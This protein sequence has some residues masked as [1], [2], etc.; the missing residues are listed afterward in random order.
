[1]PGV[2]AAGLI[3]LLPLQASGYNGDVVPEGRTFP[4]GQA[5]LAEQRFVTPGYFRALG[6]PLVR[7]RL[8]TEEDAEADTPVVMVNETLAQRFWPGQDPVGRRIR[9]GDDEYKAIV[10]VVRDVRQVALA[11]DT[12]SEVYL[13]PQPRFA[14]N[15]RTASLAVRAT[16]AAGDMGLAI[17]RAVEAVDPEQPVYDVQTME[18]VVA[19]SVADR[20]LNV[21]LVG[22]FA[23]VALLLAALGVYGVIS[24]TVAQGTREIGIRMSLGAQRRD[25]FRLVVGQGA[26]LAAVGMG[27]GLLAALG[28]TR[29]MAS[30]LFT[31]GARDPLTFVSVPVLLLA[32]A[33][34]ACA[35]PALRATRVE[36]SE[37]LRA[38]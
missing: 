13:P 37:A 30:L 3:N 9:V 18:R 5:P 34:A 8:L 2:E 26:L 36:P 28:L 14:G 10:G 35:I 15:L 29:L 12:R 31:V 32:V 1:L 21:T 6:I 20:R 17:R 25:V 23:A 22:A 33:L 4:P 38:E 24:Y 7:G 19:N 11:Q 16:P 27:V